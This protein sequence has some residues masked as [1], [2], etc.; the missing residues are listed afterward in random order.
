MLVLLSQATPTSDEA[1]A[2][3]KLLRCPVCQ[4][5]PIADS[6]ASMA[7]SMMQR[8]SEMLAAGQSREQILEFFVE[9]YGEWVLLDPKAQG[10]NLL[11]WLIPT[12]V[13]LFGF[14]VAWRTLR[15]KTAASQ[16]ATQETPAILQTQLDAVRREVDP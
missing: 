15:L 8:V 7:Q 10:S 11:L 5:M 2:V 9:R 14:A 12:L 6:P 4:G 16:G 1:H 13:V 3:G